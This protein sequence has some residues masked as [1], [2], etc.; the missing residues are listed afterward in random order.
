IGGFANI[1]VLY[2]QKELEFNKQFIYHLTG[3]L[4]D[5]AIS[6]TAAIVLK[7]VWALVFGL[8]AGNIARLFIGYKIHPYRPR[9]NFDFDKAR[10]LFGFGKWILASSILVFLVTQGDDIFVGKLLGATTLGFYQIAY[11]LSNA[12][13][14]EI[15]HVISQVAFPAY[16]KLQDNTES[17]GNAYLKTL[18]LVSFVSIPLAGGIFVLAPDFVRIFL[19]EKWVSIVSVM[20]ILALAGLVR[21]IQATTG[22][23]FQAIGKPKID[24][25]WQ[26]I[27]LMTLVGSI[28][29]LTRLWG[30][31][32]TSISVFLSIFITF[33]GCSLMVVKV[34]GCEIKSY[35]KAVACPLVAGI[36]MV[37]FIVALK[38]I[39]SSSG[40]YTVFFFVIIGGFV[41]LAVIYLLSKLFR[42]NIGA[43]ARSCWTSLRN[44]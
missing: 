22:P 2:F 18:Q 8:L 10:E 32:G 7:S 4:A 27:R 17:L 11:K 38:K 3:T 30:I 36:I 37:F 19:G 26:V 23:L 31:L 21:S 20:Q 9:L 12:P 44:N 15:T 33:V 41:Y 6:V 42:Y 39:L 14:T 16:S 29:P 24:A 28:Y 34:T 35:N 13:V 1:G 40:I 25:Q 5:F 43:F